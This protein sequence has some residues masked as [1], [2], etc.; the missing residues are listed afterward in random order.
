[1]DF[2]VFSDARAGRETQQKRAAARRDLQVP[3]RQ[4]GTSEC[5]RVA[6]CT[7]VVL[8]AGATQGLLPDAR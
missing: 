1:M 3:G 8:S 5:G 6:T 4:L 7:A 2:V